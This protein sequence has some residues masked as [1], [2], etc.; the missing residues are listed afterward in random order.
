MG[1]ESDVCC[2]YGLTAGFERA[3]SV[4]G[5]AIADQTNSDLAGLAEGSG[6]SQPQSH[7]GGQSR[8]PEVRCSNPCHSAN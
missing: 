2:N 5:R 4:T 6:A 1:I 3:T 7:T 8:R